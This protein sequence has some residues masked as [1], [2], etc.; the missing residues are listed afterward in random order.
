MT[1]SHVHRSRQD[2]SLPLQRTDAGS[3]GGGPGKPRTS[4]GNPATGLWPKSAW[5]HWQESFS[6]I[7]YQNEPG[8]TAPEEGQGWR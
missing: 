7:F 4:S 3:R 8:V 2:H 6:G 1:S 5:K